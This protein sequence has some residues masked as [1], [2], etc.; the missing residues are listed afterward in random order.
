[1]L[2]EEGLL[3][4]DSTLAEV[5]PDAAPAMDEGYRKV[6]LEQL[7]SHRAGAPAGTGRRALWATFWA[8]TGTPT[9]AR[10]IALQRIT[11]NAPEHEPGAQHEYSNYGFA[12]AGLMCEQVAGEP[13]E[14]LLLERL[15]APLGITT[16]GWGAPGSEDEIDQPRGHKYGRPVEPGR[17]ADNPPVLSPAGRLHLSLADWAKYIAWHLRGAEGTG[18]LLAPETFRRLHTP[19]E[20]FEYA[21]G[22]SVPHRDW[23]AGRVLAHTGSNTMWYCV[24]WAAPKKGFAVLVATNEAGDAAAKACDEVAWALIQR[25]LKLEQ[26]PGG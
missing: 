11:E 18:E 19:A 17:T 23:A 16:A 2:V 14:K 22:W 15:L 5:F 26:T 25:R 8:H 21:L 13:F 4:W 3:R 1:L 6:T 7:L 10:R 24:V 12:L 9:E 20:G